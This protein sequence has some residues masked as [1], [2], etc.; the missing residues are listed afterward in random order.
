[1]SLSSVHPLSV[2]QKRN[3]VWIIH[4]KI[5]HWNLRPAESDWLNESLFFECVQENSSATPG[6]LTSALFLIWEKEKSESICE[7][8]L[9]VTFFQYKSMEQMYPIIW[10]TISPYHG[11]YSL[12]LLL[13]LSLWHKIWHLDWL[14]SCQLYTQN[15]KSKVLLYI[16]WWAKFICC[17]SRHT[18]CMFPTSNLTT[19]I[20]SL[21]SVDLGIKSCLW[22]TRVSVWEQ[23]GWTWHIMAAFGTNN[24]VKT[25]TTLPL[26]PL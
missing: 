21:W 9:S 11:L 12:Y 1:M 23:N 18:D 20:I 5:K 19:S 8:G 14:S 22:K 24:S 15:K 16:Y 25:A 2:F 4:Y 13:F 26:C 17:V 7:S 3:A 10:F 6:W